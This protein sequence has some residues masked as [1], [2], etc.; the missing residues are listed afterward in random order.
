MGKAAR[1]SP[2]VERANEGKPASGSQNAQ[3]RFIVERLRGALPVLRQLA[4]SGAK[5]RETIGGLGRAIES[6]DIIT[7]KGDEW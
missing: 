4:G 1:K 5:A 2:A 7:R 6:Y 3:A